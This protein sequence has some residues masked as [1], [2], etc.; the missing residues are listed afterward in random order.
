MAP[1]DLSV[2]C[3]PLA[4]GTHVDSQPPE[5]ATGAPGALS[6]TQPQERQTLR[7]AS[8]ERLRAFLAATPLELSKPA[9][10]GTGLKLEPGKLDIDTCVADE[11]ISTVSADCFLALGI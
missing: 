2:A 1:A 4:S 3:E 5:L 6:S 10:E 7:A 8:D 11:F 9:P